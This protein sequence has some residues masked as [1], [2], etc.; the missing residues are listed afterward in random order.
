MKRLIWTVISI[1]LLLFSLQCGNSESEETQAGK[2][3]TETG[4]EINLTGD[5]QS[6]DDLLENLDSESIEEIYDRVMLGKAPDFMVY[7]LNRTK[8]TLEDYKDYVILLNFW[9]ETSPIS[10]RQFPILSTVQDKFR[11]SKFTVLG[12]FMDQKTREDIQEYADMNRLSYPI[13]YPIDR[14]IYNSYGV[15]M[16]G[17]SIL[18]DRKGNVVGHFYDDPGIERLEKVIELFL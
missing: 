10:K 1:C 17:I 14:R 18:I 4:S 3:N 13:V 5:E 8:I 9:S 15:E 12:V 16:P 11:D 2:E 7:D 6:I